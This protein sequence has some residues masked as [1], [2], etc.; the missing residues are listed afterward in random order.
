MNKNWLNILLKNISL[1]V[2]IAILGVIYITNVHL[3]ERKMIKIKKM[4]KEI[5]TLRYKYMD[6]KQSLLYTSAPSI[7]GKKVEDRG[8]KQTTKAPTVLKNEVK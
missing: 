3:A 5:E 7:I 4:E 8:L 6:V 1:V 2:F